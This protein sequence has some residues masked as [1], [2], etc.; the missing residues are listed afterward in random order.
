MPSLSDRPPSGVICGKYP[1]GNTELARSSASTINWFGTA[2][3]SGLAALTSVPSNVPGAKLAPFGLPAPGA[4]LLL[5]DIIT[6]LL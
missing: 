2:L 6:H 5:T 4:H 1:A 3:G